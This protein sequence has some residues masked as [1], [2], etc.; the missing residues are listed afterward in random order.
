MAQQLRVSIALAEDSDSVPSTHMVAHNHL[1]SRGV[2]VFFW[3]LCI[4]VVHGCICRQEHPYTDKNK[5][6]M[7]MISLPGHSFVTAE[8]FK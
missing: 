5:Q 8:S 3:P 1:S 7:Y 2:V 4:Y 6:M